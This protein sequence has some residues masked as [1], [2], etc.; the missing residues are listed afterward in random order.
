M[1]AA[2]SRLWLRWAARRNGTIILQVSTKTRLRYEIH[3]KLQKRARHVRSCATRAYSGCRAFTSKGS[4][5]EVANPTIFTS[6][7][8]RGDHGER[9]DCRDCKRR[10]RPWMRLERDSCSRAFADG[11]SRTR[12]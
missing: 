4:D 9:T 11:G 2:R 12:T 6:P 8:A 1:A 3:R 5:A 10:M 7:E